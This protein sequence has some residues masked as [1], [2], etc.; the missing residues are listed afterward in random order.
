MQYNSK[1][2]GILNFGSQIE[3]SFEA[4]NLNDKYDVIKNDII[5]LAPD[6]QVNASVH[7]N[8]SGITLNFF[9]HGRTFVDMTPSM[10]GV[11]EISNPDVALTKTA[12]DFTAIVVFQTDQGLWRVDYSVPLNFGNI[13]P[14][15]LYSGPIASPLSFNGR[16]DADHR[17]NNRITICYSDNN[18]IVLDCQEDPFMTSTFSQVAGYPMTIFSCSP[19]EECLKVDVAFGTDIVNNDNIVVSFVNQIPWVTAAQQNVVYIENGIITTIT[20]FPYFQNGIMNPLHVDDTYVH[21]ANIC[22]EDNVLVS[23]QMRWTLVRSEMDGITPGAYPHISAVHSANGIISTVFNYIDDLNPMGPYGPS[24]HFAPI[25]ADMGQNGDVDIVFRSNFGLIAG[26][27]VTSAM[28]PYAGNYQDW[29][30]V[31]TVPSTPSKGSLSVASDGKF[32]TI[33]WLAD[34]R[35]YYKTLVTGSVA[36]RLSSFS[37]TTENQKIEIVLYDMSGRLV[38]RGEN[39]DLSIKNGIYLRIDGNTKELVSITDGKISSK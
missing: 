9:G 10:F 35:L 32:Y 33:C 1:A 8:A 14:I 16:I 25:C 19:P 36:Y 28:S 20:S 2:Q 5:T 26:Q 17:T 3:A 4:P 12:T 11:G 29:N 30:K 13:A 27:G 38:Y 21:Y 6:W 24:S 18:Q 37:S 23:G 15:Q 39:V 7:E 31:N 34:N 22:S